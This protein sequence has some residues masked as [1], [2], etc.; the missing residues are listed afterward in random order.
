[1]SII[2]IAEGLSQNNKNNNHHNNNNHHHNNQNNNKMYRYIVH[3]QFLI[4][5]MAVFLHPNRHQKTS[6]TS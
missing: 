6:P 2:F 1:M 5:A 3:V 4:T